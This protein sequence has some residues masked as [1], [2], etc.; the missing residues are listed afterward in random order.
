MADSL[1]QFMSTMGT[2]PKSSEDLSYSEA[3]RAMNQMLSESLEP[4]S[5]GAFVVAERWKG[6]STDELAGFLDHIRE[7]HV[8]FFEPNRDFYLDVAGRFDGKVNSVNTDLPASVLAA[9]AGVPIF[10]HSS[11]SVPTQEGTT[12]LDVLEELGFPVTPSPG[13]SERALDEVGFSYSAQSVYAPDL[14]DLKPFRRELGVRCFLNTIESMVNPANA[15]IHV[16]SF[17]HLT[18]ASKVTETFARL[19][20]GSPE[21]VTMIQ[22]IEGQTELRS[23]DCLI[24]DWKDGSL[25]D[26][27]YDSR[28]FGLDFDRSDL[29]EIGPSPSRSA[30]L[31]MRLLRAEQVPE[32]YE[33]SV[34]WNTAARLLSGRET[35]SLR[36]GIELARKTL[37]SDAAITLWNDVE[38][39][40]KGG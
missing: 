7:E 32:P 5:F 36:D 18:F 10:T 20:S 6:Q 40:F 21:S 23:G 38:E 33:E 2:G 26:H 1:K 16:G 12:F 29:D 37:R 35:D 8:Q 27:E 9:A 34:I 13:A 24:A 22:G 15:P 14:E 25:D 39:V 31:M 4:V 28:E 11:R 30:D 19:E 3:R 17:Y